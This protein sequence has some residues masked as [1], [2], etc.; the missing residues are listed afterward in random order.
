MIH[1]YIYN[2]STLTLTLKAV[3]GQRYTII[4]YYIILQC[5]IYDYM[6]DLPLKPFVHCNWKLC[7]VV[8]TNAVASGES[9]SFSG[10]VVE[11]TRSDGLK[12]SSSH[13]KLGNKKRV[14]LCHTVS[15]IS[16]TASRKKK[17]K[18]KKKKNYQSQIRGYIY[19]YLSIYKNTI[20]RLYNIIYIYMDI[21]Q[22]D[23]QCVFS[24]WFRHVQPPIS[25]IGPSEK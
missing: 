2:Y 13:Q 18:K 9:G 1:C 5:T 23:I 7:L 11:Q 25:K 4:Q 22:I 6:I 21:I 8:C 3:S 24:W 15:Y 16:Y 12:P 19:I 10:E 14:I 20:D 17:K